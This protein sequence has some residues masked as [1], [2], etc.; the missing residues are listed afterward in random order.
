MHLSSENSGWLKMHICFDRSFQLANYNFRCIGDILM[1]LPVLIIESR[2]CTLEFHESGH[3]VKLYC[4][5][6]CD[7][8]RPH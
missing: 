4:I 6:L 8:V 2:T 3:C 5:S 1:T 7:Y